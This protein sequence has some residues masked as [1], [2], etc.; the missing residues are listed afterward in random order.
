MTSVEIEERKLA[1]EERRLAEEIIRRDRELELREKEIAFGREKLDFEKRGSWRQIYS[2]I[3]VAVLAGLLGL[4]GNFATGRQNLNLEREKQKSELDLQKQRQDADVTLERQKQ[5]ST[6]L[7]K[8]AE[9]PDDKQRARNFLFFSEG[10]YLKFTEAYQ[11]YLRET[12]GL[13]PGQQVPPPSFAELVPIPTRTNKSLEAAKLSTLRELLGIPC[14]GAALC[15]EPTN[16]RLQDLI[17]IESIG[18]MRLR[19]LRPAVA[20]VKR[21]LQK[22]QQVHPDLFAQLR[23]QGMFCCRRLRGSSAFSPHSWG[24]A[25]DLSVGDTL[26]PIGGDKA[27]Y[28]I[29]LMAPLFEAEGFAWGADEN[30]RPNTFH[31][32][33]SETKLREWHDAGMLR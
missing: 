10:G 6:L 13:S 30:K 23:S 31:F 1:L 9:Q 8:L 18:N 16:P 12:A 11:T 7:L 17:V 19:G 25:L 3:G 4:A 15:T 32:S 26:P 28:G 20:A 27:Q 5:E 14:E 24:T 2:P 21:V 29:T 22:V 33:V